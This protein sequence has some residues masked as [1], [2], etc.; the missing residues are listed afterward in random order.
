MEAGRNKAFKVAEMHWSSS[1]TRAV[2][3]L[4]IDKTMEYAK[5]DAKE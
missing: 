4:L 2:M 1:V 3:N 5:I